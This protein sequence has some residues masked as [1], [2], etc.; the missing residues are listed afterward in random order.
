MQPA[1]AKHELQRISSILLNPASPHGALFTVCND[2]FQLLEKILALELASP[3]H[4]EDVALDSGRAIG[5]FWAAMCIRDF[6]RTQT[7]LLG[8]ISAVQACQ[9]KFPNQ[10]IHVLYAGTGPFATLALPLTTCFSPEEI[11][12]TMLEI[13][14][15]SLSYLE[16]IIETLEINHYI[17]DLKCCDAT[18]V[19]ATPFQPYQILLSETMQ[20][21]LQNEPQ[22][23]ITTHLLQYLEPD[24]LLVPEQILLQAGFLNTSFDEQGNFLP[25]EQACYLLQEVFDLSIPGLKKIEPD[26]NQWAAPWIFPVVTIQIPETIDEK[27]TNFSLFTTIRVHGQ[28]VLKFLESGLTQPSVLLSTYR[29]RERNVQKIELQ[30]QQSNKPGFSLNVV[31]KQP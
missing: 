18:T 10:P 29:I 15:S 2:M 5:P 25:E 12:F 4:R 30:Y 9:K 22:V 11:Q 24:G 13:N 28:H 17:R 31:E 21:G 26:A 8:L 1:A 7:Y 6:M 27:F 14:P 20:N 16:K 23:A 3:D 19:D